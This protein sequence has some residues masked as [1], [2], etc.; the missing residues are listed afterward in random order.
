M[1]D[2]ARERERARECVC[3][4]VSGLI[5]RFFFL[6]AFCPPPT[7]SSSVLTRIPITP[8]LL[9]EALISLHYTMQERFS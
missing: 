9:V 8:T 5:K 1:V 2:G 6:A 3:V 7:Y 4:C